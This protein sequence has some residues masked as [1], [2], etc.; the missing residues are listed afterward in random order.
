MYRIIFISGKW[1]ALNIYS[2]DIKDDMDNIET[3]LEEGTIVAFSDDLQQFAAAVGVK[4]EEIEVI[5]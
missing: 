3:C 4:P 5:K 2:V 1:F